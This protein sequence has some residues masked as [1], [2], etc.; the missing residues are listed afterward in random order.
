VPG[1]VGAVALPS[2]FGNLVVPDAG[3]SRVF[4]LAS[5]NPTYSLRAFDIITRAQT[6]A[7]NLGNVGIAAP[8]TSLIRYGAKGLAF[9]DG[10]DIVFVES[11]DIIP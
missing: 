7:V 8:P 6:G 2:P 5:E 11:T 10:D 4:Y 3:L 9:R 1:L